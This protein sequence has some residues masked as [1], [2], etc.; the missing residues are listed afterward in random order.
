MPV[1][2]IRAWG[3]LTVVLLVAPLVVLA[4]GDRRGDRAEIQVTNEAHIGF[5]GR[6]GSS[7]A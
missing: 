4:Q 6:K 5:Q 3:I 1:K 2:W 7:L